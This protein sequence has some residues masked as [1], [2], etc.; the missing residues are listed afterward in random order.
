MYIIENCTMREGVQGVPFR[1][2]SIGNII[3]EE[4]EEL[5]FLIYEEVEEDIF[6]LELNVILKSK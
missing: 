3:A 6:I 1:L 2:K 5:I 4:N